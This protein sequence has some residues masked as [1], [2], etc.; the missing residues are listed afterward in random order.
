MIELVAELLVPAHVEDGDSEGPL[1]SVL[2]VGLLYVAH[3]RHQLLARHRLLILKSGDVCNGLD[4]IS[5]FKT[6]SQLQ[7]LS[8]NATLRP[9]PH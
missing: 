9:L 6:Q 8:D 3:E 5:K 4:P 1:A 7:C 2:R